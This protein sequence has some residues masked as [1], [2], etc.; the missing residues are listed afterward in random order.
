MLLAG[1]SALVR[2]TGLAVALA[3]LALVSATCGG[4]D[5]GPATP[6][7][8]TPLGSLVLSGG[9][10]THVLVG[11]ADIGKCGPGPEATAALLDDVSGT[12]FT[13]G[14]NSYPRGSLEDYR[15]CYDPSWGR[16]RGRTR[17][18]PGNHEYE[19]PNAQGYFDYFGAAGGPIGLGYYSYTLGSWTILA[20][21][22]E[23]P[24]DN[25]SAQ[26]QWVRERLA[27]SPTR[28]TAVY[29]H[30][31]LFSS[32]PN[33][34][35]RDMR[36]LWRVLYQHDVDI[37]INGHDH[38]YERFAPQN[39]DGVLDPERG[40]R[41]FIVG[42]GGADTYQLT[43]TAPN[44]E[45]L[46]SVWGVAAFTLQNGTYTWRFIPAEGAAFRDAGVAQCH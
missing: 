7:G 39:P 11:A 28:C 40:I 15:K 35:N 31:P 9:S 32:G 6:A 13:A 19:T 22:S 4:S 3:T 8:P 44:S 18:V 33:G 42:T 2:R 20:L 14:D 37:V 38:I 34:P 23:L 16:H 21:N 29:W 30:R 26:L 46:A 5:S 10:Q 1:A 25:S 43:R 27:T 12:V 17:P 24:I 36:E 45:A 41:Q